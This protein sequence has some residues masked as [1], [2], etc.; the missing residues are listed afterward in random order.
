[1]KPYMVLVLLDSYPFATAV[2][3]LL[4]FITVL[5][6][7]IAAY[8]FVPILNEARRE[9]RKQLVDKNASIPVWL[10]RPSH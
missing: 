9:R 10:G 7:G 2:L 5:S 4:L 3:L 6:F 1:M 8:M